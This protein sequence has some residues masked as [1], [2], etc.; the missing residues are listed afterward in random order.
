MESSIVSI[1]I[2]CYNYGWL[3]SETLDSVLAQTHQEWECLVIDDGSTDTTRAVAEEYRAR[4]ARFYYMHQANGG[5]SSARNHGLRLARGQYVQFLDADDM[6]APQKLALQVAVLQTQPVVD[7]IYGDVRYF[8]HGDLS[9]LSRSLTMQAIV[10]MNE[11]SGRGEPVLEKLVL[12]NQLVI[13]APLMRASLLRRVGPFSEMLHSMEDWEFWMRC[14]LADACFQYDDR[15]E[16]WALV[17]VHSTSVSQNQPRMRRYEIDVR[18][19]I[20]KKLG[21][22]KAIE[23]AKINQERLTNLVL[24]S[25]VDDMTRGSLWHGIRGFIVLGHAQG[26]YV[27]QCRNIA[28]WFLRRMKKGAVLS[29]SGS[30]QELA[31]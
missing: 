15:P 18:R 29:S 19:W 6:L 20:A 31:A 1:I 28:Y 5:M 16:M 27:H 13:N 3:L 24:N 12:H 7:I 25:A 10:W 9:V 21:Q 23:A 22:I 30:N 11:L 26:N 17:R 8:N 4:D 2:P 14:A